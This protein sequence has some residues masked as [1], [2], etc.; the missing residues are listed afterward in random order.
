MS[1]G[2]LSHPSLNVF[3][4]LPKSKTNL[5]TFYGENWYFRLQICYHESKANLLS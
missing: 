1:S 5:L 2:N 4:T 3:V